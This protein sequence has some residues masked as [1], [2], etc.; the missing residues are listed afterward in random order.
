MK[1]SFW[2]LHAVGFELSHF[3]QKCWVKIAKKPDSRKSRNFCIRLV[4]DWEGLVVVQW[5]P[6]SPTTT[7]DIGRS[8]FPNFCSFSY[9]SLKWLGVWEQRFVAW[10]T[11]ARPHKLGVKGFHLEAKV[12]MTFQKTKGY[13]LRF[14]CEKILGAHFI[15]DNSTYG[16][17]SK[18]YIPGSRRKLLVLEVQGCVYWKRGD[19]LQ[20]QIPKLRCWA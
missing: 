4:G 6:G 12:E 5:E 20:L 16:Y 7:S 3:R 18:K 10:V 17:G 13:P 1:G 14:F 8:R 11:I 19:F 9:F 15:I 2:I